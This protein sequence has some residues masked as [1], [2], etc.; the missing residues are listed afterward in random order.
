MV[1]IV[2]MQFLQVALYREIIDNSIDS[3]FDKFG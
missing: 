3:M 2:V 1:T